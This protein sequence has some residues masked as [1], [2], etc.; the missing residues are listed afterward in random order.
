MATRRTAFTLIELLVVMGIIAVLVGLLLPGLAK[1]RKQANRTACLSNLRQVYFCFEFYAQSFGDQIPIGYD[2]PA[3][4]EQSDFYIRNSA[5][6]TGSPFTSLFGLFIDAN[7]ANSPR[8]F[9][10]PS[11]GNPQYQF[12][13]P[14]NPWPP[15]M[16]QDTYAAFACRPVV[17][18]MNSVV[19]TPMQKLTRLKN[20]ALAADIISTPAIVGA[21]HSS[22]VNTLFGDGSAHYVEKGAFQTDL[23]KVGSGPF[24]STNNLNFLNT[25]VTPNTGVWGDLDRN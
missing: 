11:E 23:A 15:V 1:S 18:W 10:C 21:R 12:N 17:Y 2:G 25:T 24:S 4:A 6:P 14:Q 3:G 7:L 22:G 20:L 13:T 9:Y 5:T 19:P 16:N 8:I